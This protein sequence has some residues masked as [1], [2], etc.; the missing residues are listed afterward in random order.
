[1]EQ[2]II[3]FNRRGAICAL[4]ANKAEMG[5]NMEELAIHRNLTELQTKYFI[6]MKHVSKKHMLVAPVF[7]KQRKDCKK[8][9]INRKGYWVN[10]MTFYIVPVKMMEPAPGKYLDFTYR[11]IT[12]IY[13]SH[14]NVLKNILDQ[15]KSDK[16]TH[17]QECKRMKEHYPLCYKQKSIW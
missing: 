16:M 6:V 2:R 4:G 7:T 15:D 12:D 1:M 13:R 10:F 17:K 3:Y 5:L 9:R 11:T 8:I 14:N